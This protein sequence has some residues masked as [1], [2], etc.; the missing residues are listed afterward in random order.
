MGGSRPHAAADPTGLAQ[1][2]S[3][4][5]ELAEQRPGVARIDDVVDTERFRGPQWRTDGAQP[6]LDLRQPYGGV[7]RGRELGLERG[8]DATLEGERAP[9]AEG[10]AKRIAYRAA[11]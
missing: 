11:F 3:E 10:Q 7:R 5:G 8:L 6:G 9:L 4:L 2:R 1:R